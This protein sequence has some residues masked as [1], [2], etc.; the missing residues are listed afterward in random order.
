MSSTHVRR[1]KFIFC[2]SHPV[3]NFCQVD[4]EAARAFKENFALRPTAGLV[5]RWS[6][7][8]SDSSALVTGPRRGRL[9]RGKRDHHRRVAEPGR[10]GRVPL[11]LLSRAGRSARHLCWPGWW[12]PAAPRS[13]SSSLASLASKELLGSLGLLTPCNEAPPR[14]PPVW[15]SS[16]VQRA[17]QVLL[18]A[19]TY[20]Q[21]STICIRSL[22][23][24][25][26]GRQNQRTALW[27]IIQIPLLPTPRPESCFSN[28][29]A[30][31]NL[32]PKM[33]FHFSETSAPSPQPPSV[34]SRT[35]FSKESCSWGALDCLFLSG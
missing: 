32:W 16:W 14:L 20:R 17:L 21:Y 18:E 7:D 13:V 25:D 28:L 9:A 19:A 22:A 31:A 24:Q 30:L 8:L 10:A 11:Q 5:E 6:R 29:S 33:L 27:L 3:E 23:P 4:Y 35:G 26:V 12:A 34:P 2:L 15:T 1:T